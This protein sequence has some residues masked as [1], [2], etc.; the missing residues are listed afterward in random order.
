MGPLSLAIL[1]VVAACAAIALRFGRA[2]ERCGGTIV[3]VWV[4]A[5]AVYHLL[6]GPSG[7]DAV[8]PVEAVFDGSELVAVV[9]LALRANRTWPLWAAAAQLLCVSGHVVALI[10]H[11]GMRR[12][13]WAM[14]QL[15]QYLQLTA[16]LVGT[17]RHAR[18]R[19][20][21]RSWRAV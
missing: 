1:A 17:A 12:A 4:A 21:E 10:D 16:I 6:F 8:D 2:P 14:T 18:R 3:F 20:P 5:D 11:G 15:P 19:G 7:F 9:W 13:Y